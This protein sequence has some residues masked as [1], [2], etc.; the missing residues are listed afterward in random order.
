MK[1]LARTTPKQEEME[2]LQKALSFKEEIEKPKKPQLVLMREN[3]ILVIPPP[4]S[5]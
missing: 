4:T 5:C 3:L 2:I 1:T